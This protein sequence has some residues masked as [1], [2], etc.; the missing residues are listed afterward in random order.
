MR[1]FFAELLE[2]LQAGHKVVA[3]RI[4]RQS[5]SA[6]RSIGTRCII[7]ED[8]SLLGTIG[9]GLLEFQVMEAA[10]VA[11]VDERTSILNF[12]LTGMEVAQ[13]DM[14][15]GG[16]MDVYLEPVDPGNKTAI[17]VFEAAAKAIDTGHRGTLITLIS[18][19]ISSKDKSC[20]IYIAEDGSS[21]GFINKISQMN[22]QELEP[23]CQTRDSALT[24]LDIG[25]TLVF[26]EAVRP[27]DILY[28]FGA[29][30]VST[31]IAPLAKLVGFRVV[32]MDDRKE[33][34]NKDRFP[35]AD[36]II[37]LP[38]SKVFEHITVTDLS[39]LVIVTRG[40]ISDKDVLQGALQKSNGYIGMIGSRRKRDLIYRSLIE[41]GF[42]EERLKAVHSPIGLEIGAETPEEIAVSIVG[43][44]IQKRAGKG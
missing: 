6:P 33:F 22:R 17:D 37:T 8:G 43:E 28:L 14:I 7:R 3:A 9:G 34:A 19:G 32:V 31:C 18:E 23:L 13:T 35:G 27:D 26:S 39:Y 5:G 40:H 36:E 10:K 4:I 24:E 30:H 38:F 42:S 12:Q 29:G 44:L 1:N 20:R 25:S 41:E 15:C 11:L 16:K 21:T 2:Q